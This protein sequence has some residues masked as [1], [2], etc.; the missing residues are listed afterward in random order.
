MKQCSLIVGL[1]VFFNL[2]VIAQENLPRLA[3]VE[4]S[5]NSNM[6]K[7]I[8]DSVTVRNLVESKL[9]STGKYQIITRGEIEEL[10]LNYSIQIS[11][12]S[13]KENIEKLQLQN[14]R[15]IVTGSVDLMNNSYALT[16]K[17]LNV[18]TG[19]FYHS[20]NELI[21]ENTQEFYRGIN[22]LMDSFI[23]GIS[24]YEDNIVQRRNSAIQQY[25]VGTRG[26]GGGIIFYA[27]GNVYM[28]VSPILGEADFDETNKIIEE[29]NKRGEYS[30]WRLPTRTEFNR[31]YENLQS[32]NVANLG[33]DIYWTSEVGETNYSFPSGTKKTV[34][35]C[36]FGRGQIYEGTVLSFSRNES[37]G[38][39][40]Y[41]HVGK[42]C[43]RAV[44][45]FTF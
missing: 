17:I 32:T 12:I 39:I 43:I 41:H 42:Y 13:S 31:I 30:D 19:Q 16:I 10:L 8:Q 33:T 38:E 15:Y 27:E 14:I 7:V 40:Y 11:S 23:A 44:R 22:I 5:R 25:R 3:I 2:S 18:S 4:F 24:S 35:V 45:G 20:V 28:E 37:N 36:D 21:G 34:W 26:P 9:I 1:F 29:Y 6:E